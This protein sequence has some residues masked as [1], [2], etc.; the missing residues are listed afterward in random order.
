MEFEIIKTI[1]ESQPIS[2]ER[3][4][5]FIEKDE[6]W[7]PHWGEYKTNDVNIYCLNNVNV[8]GEG[9]VFDR[10]EFFKPALFSPKFSS[11]LG[12]RYI[13]KCY[14]TYTKIRKLDKNST[15]IFAFDYCAKSNYYHWIVDTLPRLFLIAEDL[16]NSTL[17]IPK[18]SSNYIKESIS[19][20]KTDQILELSKN[21]LLRV[22]KLIVPGYVAAPGRH[23]GNIL[24]QLRFLVWTSLSGNKL[25]VSKTDK[26][27]AS[28]KNQKYRKIE[29][30]TEVIEVLCARGFTIVYFENMSFWEQVSIMK[31]CKYFVSSHGSNMT[32][33]LFMSTG[34]KVLEINQNEDPN[35]CYWSLAKSLNLE[36]YYQFCDVVPRYNTGKKYY[37]LNNLIVDL[38]ILNR[39]LN[40]MEGN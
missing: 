37:Y 30:E 21:E 24:Q 36:Y 11:N 35:L 15:Y 8:S 17:I 31:T 13:V 26:I 27:Y 4:N 38:N 10:F 25:S 18:T 7:F 6:Q 5:N 9:I 23:N 2:L 3:P 34:S 1:F 12:I 39:N 32:N 19:I 16:K 22:K 29:N 20:F 33:I 14:L 28:R 40:I